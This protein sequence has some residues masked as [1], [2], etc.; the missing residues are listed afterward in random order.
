M[1]FLKIFMDK[2]KRLEKTIGIGLS[3]DLTISNNIIQSAEEI[4]KSTKNQIVL[5]G[6]HNIIGSINNETQNSV[7]DKNSLLL[8]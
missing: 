6:N 1:N 7:I 8:K 5:V 3:N 2:A 4:V